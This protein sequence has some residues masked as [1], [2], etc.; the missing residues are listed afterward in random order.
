MFNHKNKNRRGWIRIVEAFVAILLI[1]GIVLIVVAQ[2]QNKREDV[3]SRTYISLVSVLREVQ[4]NNTLRADI[5]GTEG[6]IE[7]DSGSF[8]AR[9]KDK[10]I[11]KTP[12]YLECTGK[13]CSTS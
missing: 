11:E 4:L 1:A 10:I 6:T 9:V 2:D 13:I 12:S 3:S 5:I 7:W 8:P